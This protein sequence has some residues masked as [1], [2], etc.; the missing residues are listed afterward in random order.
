MPVRL[1]HVNLPARDPVALARW[2]AERFDLEQDGAFAFAPGTLLVFEPGG[3][4]GPRGAGHFGFEVAS[5]AEAVRFAERFGCEPE[6]EEDYVGFKAR[7]PEGNRF[8]VYFEERAAEPPGLRPLEPG[9]AAWLKQ[10]SAPIGGLEVVSRGV[11]HRLP[12]LPGLVAEAGGERVGF[13]CYRP[14]GGA[15]ELVAIRALRERRGV[16]SALVRAVEAAAARAGA[17]RLWLV[18]SNDNVGALRFYQLAGFRLVAV[19]P[20]AVDRARALKPSIPV[21]SPDGIPCRDELELE[22]SL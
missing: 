17:R 11:L 13:A 8:E 22:K 3:V 12:D 9:D 7:D 2:Y 6:V 4:P 15:C 14:E 5:R 20:G 21:A 16:G 18:T 1:A 19:H 10:G